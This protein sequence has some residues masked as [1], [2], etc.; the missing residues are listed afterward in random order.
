MVLIGELF[1]MGLYLVCLCLIFKKFGYAWWKALIPFYNLVIQLRIVKLSYMYLIYVFVFVFSYIL[2]I[3]LFYITAYYDVVNILV[4]YIL[5]I[6]FVS[7]FVTSALAIYIIFQ[8]VFVYR[9]ARILGETKVF[10][11]LSLFFSFNLHHLLYIFSL[12]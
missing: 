7:I 5:P 2:C 9:L 10:R 3:L 12:F 4:S 6:I 8:I 11:I 1:L